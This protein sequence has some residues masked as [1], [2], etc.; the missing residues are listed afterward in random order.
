MEYTALLNK[1]SQLHDVWGAKDQSISE[2]L[3]NCL[4]SEL[5]WRST[6]VPTDEPLCISA[7]I[8][9]PLRDL[10]AVKIEDRPKQLWKLIR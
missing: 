8:G 9:L 5:M 4:H 1:A 10:V 2:K 7:L 6:S 3:L